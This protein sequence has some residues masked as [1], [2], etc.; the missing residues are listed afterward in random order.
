MNNKFPCSHP[1]VSIF[2]EA[3]E[4]ECRCQGTQSDN[5]RNGHDISHDCGKATTPSLPLELLE[6]RDECFATKEKDKKEK[7][8]KEKN[9]KAKV[10]KEIKNESKRQFAHFNQFLCSRQ[11]YRTHTQQI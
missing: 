10:K 7:N 4:E 2:V 3:L 6:C 9:T 11:N 5:M 8:K 1:D